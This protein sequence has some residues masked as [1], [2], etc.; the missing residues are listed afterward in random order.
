M[1]V[2]YSFKA[3]SLHAGYRSVLVLTSLANTRAGQ[4]E[5]RDPPAPIRTPEWSSRLSGQKR[6]LR[7]QPEHEG[8]L[9]ILFR[10]LHFPL[11]ISPP[12]TSAFGHRVN[13]IWGTETWLAAVRRT[14]RNPYEA[15]LNST[16]I[17]SFGRYC[18]IM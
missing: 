2:E 11:Y 17:A 9:V 4:S 7:T 16:Q 12:L 5:L 1:R 14:N 10:W 3:C 15:M 6:I 13:L 8:Q 18:R